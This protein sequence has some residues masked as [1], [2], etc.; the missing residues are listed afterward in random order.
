VIGDIQGLGEAS[1]GFVCLGLT[2]LITVD[3]Q[4]SCCAG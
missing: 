4:M 1:F 3:E 2:W